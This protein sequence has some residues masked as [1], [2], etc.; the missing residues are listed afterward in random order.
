MRDYLYCEEIQLAPLLREFKTVRIFAIKEGFI[1]KY[2]V[3]ID[4]N[5]YNEKKYLKCLIKKEIILLSM[6]VRLGIKHNKYFESYLGELIKEIKEE[7][8]N[9]K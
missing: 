9:D 5:E 6:S 8:K 2:E 1:T 4:D 7:N 3:N